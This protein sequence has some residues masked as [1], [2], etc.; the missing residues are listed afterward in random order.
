MNATLAITGLHV[1]R[2]FPVCKPQGAA[3]T[4]SVSG[5]SVAP[6]AAQGRVAAAATRERARSFQL[7]GGTYRALEGA[8]ARFMAE[9]ISVIGPS[10]MPCRAVVKFKI[11]P[12]HQMPDLRGKC[13]ADLAGT[14]SVRR[15]SH[16]RQP[17]FKTR[18]EGVCFGFDGQGSFHQSYR[19]R[20]SFCGW[21]RTGDIS[22]RRKSGSNL[23]SVRGASFRDSVDRA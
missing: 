17:E 6:L 19:S 1:G 13:L 21:F 16:R 15:V 8:E 7:T 2:S 11:M 23:R 20:A 3:F 5:I 22:R 4:E 12:S 18:D 9:P 14:I 10:L